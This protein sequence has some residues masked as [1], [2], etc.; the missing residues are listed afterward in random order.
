MLGVSWSQWAVVSI[1]PRSMFEKSPTSGGIVRSPIVCAPC[2]FA[3][4]QAALLFCST[5]FT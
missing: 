1:I 2:W 3:G 5:A 4:S